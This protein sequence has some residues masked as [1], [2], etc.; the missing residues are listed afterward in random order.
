MRSRHPGLGL[1]VLAVL[2]FA[3]A[4]TPARQ[5]SGTG[6]APAA[7]PVVAVHPPKVAIGTWAEIPSLQP[8]LMN[9]PAAG[10]HMDAGYLVNSPLVVLDPTG[11]PLPRLA[12]EL[13]S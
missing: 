7:A 2:A 13:P 12:T 1:I 6:A 11:A 3:C 5:S 4:P 8:K 9:R 10:Y